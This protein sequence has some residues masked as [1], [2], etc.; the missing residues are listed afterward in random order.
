[1]T[2]RIFH[3]SDPHFGAENRNALDVFAEAVRTEGADVVLCTGDLTQRATHPQFEA[4][5]R[6]F[7]QFDVPV[8]MCAGN[9][10]MPYYNMWERL[11]DPYRRYR[12]VAERVASSFESSHVVLIPLVT[13][14][15]I[16]P[17]FPWV[18]GL[19]RRPA[20]DLTLSRLRALEGD[21]RHK[22]VF[23]HHP[24]LPAREGLKNPTINGDRAFAALAQAGAQA[25]ISGHVHIP[26]DQTRQAGGQAMRMLGVGTLSTRLRGAPP[27]FQIVSCAQGEALRVERRILSERAPLA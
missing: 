19:I 25:V 3:L 10:D 2:T 8:V 11:S 12:K 9:H 1:M 5:A 26:F 20:L 13:T 16:Q 23:C 21:A 17:R 27:S 14:V 6:Y 24:L 4:A 15:N 7:G 22:I 18:D